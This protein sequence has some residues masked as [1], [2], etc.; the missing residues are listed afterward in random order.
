MPLLLSPPVTDILSPSMLRAVRRCLCARAS[1]RH[2]GVGR[3]ADALPVVAAVIA[4]HARGSDYA[5]DD[6]SRQR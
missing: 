4:P 5:A 6:G 3:H 1:L 2:G